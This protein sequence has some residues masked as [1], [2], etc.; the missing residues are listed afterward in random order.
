MS[1]PIEAPLHPLSIFSSNAL[2]ALFSFLYVASLYVAQ[3]SRLRFPAAPD[4][5]VQPASRDDPAIIRARLTGVAIASMLS[6]GVVYLLVWQSSFT[7]R[8]FAATLSVLGVRWPGSISPLLQAPLLFLGPIYGSYLGRTLPGQTKY[9]VQHDLFDMFG[10][11]IGFRNYV[12]GPFTEE[13][14][15]RACILSAYA[16]G[17]AIRWKMIT[18]AP[19]VFGPAHVHHAWE[20]YNRCGRSKDALR[21]ATMSS[22]FQTAY[23]TLFGAYA[24]FLFLRTSSLLPPLTAHIFCNIMGLPDIHGEMQRFP[25]QRQR[26]IG[27]YAL[28]IILFISTLQ[29]WTETHTSFYWR[30]P[31]AFW[32]VVL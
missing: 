26:I 18:F 20:V 3:N 15:F 25:E 23:T 8:S 9:S 21:Y 16:M 10:T 19:L 30:A 31:E 4:V 12:W 11:W 7:S 13:V 27:A 24:S 17:G 5:R 28:G 6:C 1:P 14:V 29:S 22:A 32:P 2:A